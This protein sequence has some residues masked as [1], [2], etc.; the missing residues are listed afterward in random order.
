MPRLYLVSAGDRGARGRLAAV[1]GRYCSCSAIGVNLYD[2]VLDGCRTSLT[3]ERISEL[4]HGGRVTRD[5]P[6]KSSRSLTWRTVD[7]VFP[8]LKYGSAVSGDAT[9]PSSSF[10]PNRST[11]VLA[12]SIAAVVVLAVTYFLSE[13]SSPAF[14]VPSPTNKIVAAGN[15]VRS[16]HTHAYSATPAQTATPNQ[17]QPRVSA[18]PVRAN[19]T[20]TSTGTPGPKSQSSERAPGQ[21]NARIASYN[22]AVELTRQSRQVLAQEAAMAARARVELDQVRA[23]Q[24]R[25]AGRDFVTPLDKDVPINVGGWS[26][27]VRIHDTGIASFNVWVDGSFPR[28]M[29]KEHGLSHSG[30]DETLIYSNGRASL[31]YVAEISPERNHCILRVRDR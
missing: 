25:A 24:K 13:A 10:V 8:L 14:A 9:P 29:V 12:A 16:A 22:A 23:E 28:K 26:V 27:T 15:T 5:A 30:A 31:Y 19:Q 3:T 17:L 18:T 4:F 6:C 1:V 11:V 21:A 2:I 7:E 20:V